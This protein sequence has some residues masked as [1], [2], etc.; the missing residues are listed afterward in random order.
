[1]LST[2]ELAARRTRSGDI[3]AP[4]GTKI[5]TKSWMTEAPLRMLMNNLCNPPI[6]NISQN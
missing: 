1:M 6:F 4:T 3:K 5:S 2:E